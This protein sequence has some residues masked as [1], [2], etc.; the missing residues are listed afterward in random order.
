[1]KDT[2][3]QATATGG[4]TRSE[5]RET[6]NELGSAAFAKLNVLEPGALYAVAESKNCDVV[7]ESGLSDRASRKSLRWYVDCKNGNRFMVDQKQAQDALNRERAGHLQV[8]ELAASCTAEIA[9][10]MICKLSRP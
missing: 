2:A 9:A 5:Y 4:Y 1:M 6:Y 10:W 3:S 7:E 8:T